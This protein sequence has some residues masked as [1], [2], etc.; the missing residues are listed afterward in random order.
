VWDDDLPPLDRQD[1]ALS[2]SKNAPAY[3]ARSLLYQLT[4]VDL[5]AI[6]GLHASTVQ[7]IVAEIGLDMGKWPHAKAFCA[8]LGLAPRHEISGGKVLRRSTLK[9]HNRAGQALR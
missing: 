6:P 5:V 9:T 3:D 8:W 4:G 2:H 1:K 7:T